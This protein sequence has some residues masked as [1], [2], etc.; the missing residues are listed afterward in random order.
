MDNNTNNQGNLPDAPQ[1]SAAGGNAASGGQ[2]PQEPMIPLSVLNKGLGKDFKDTDTAI[3]SLKDT[4]SY[5]AEVGVLKT[6]LQT[7]E[8]N[9]SPAATGEIASLK[10]Q[11]EAIQEDAFFDRNAEIKSIRPI[12]KAFAKANGKTLAETI[13][14]AEIKELIAKVSGFDKSQGMRTVLESNPRLASSQTKIT[15]AQD[16]SATRSRK[17]QA[18]AADLAVQAV[19]EA[20][21][22]FM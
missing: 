16:L 19:M 14:V 12:V 8:G 17:A 7:L 22:D 1:L 3:K 18:E 10:G 20:T 2:N 21:P 13:E 9:S 6:K 5:V 4:Q 15:K 11:L